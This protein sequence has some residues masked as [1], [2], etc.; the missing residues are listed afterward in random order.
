[1]SLKFLGKLVN[2]YMYKY[3]GMNLGL[4]NGVLTRI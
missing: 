3:K 1:M 4:C 2:K